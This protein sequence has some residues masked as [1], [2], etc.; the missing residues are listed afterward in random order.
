MSPLYL[1]NNKLLVRSEYGNK[2]SIGP[3]CCCN[4][5]SSVDYVYCDCPEIIPWGGNVQELTFTINGNNYTLCMNQSTYN[6]LIRE[7][8]NGC[9][10]FG[11]YNLQAYVGS[12]CLIK[13]IYEL[14]NFPG[15]ACNGNGDFCD[16]LITSWTTTFGNCVA[17]N[18]VAGN[19]C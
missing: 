8:M 19:F 1:F 14:G 5:S 16:Y 2:L 17:T 10:Y 11:F 3:N 4:S 18:V 9:Y 12:S 7:Q 13:V 15:C 6:G